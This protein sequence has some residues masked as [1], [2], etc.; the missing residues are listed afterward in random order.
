LLIFVSFFIVLNLT[1]FSDAF[2]FLLA[3]EISLRDL[4]TRLTKQVYDPLPMTRFRPNI[5]VDFHIEEGEE[6][7]PP[8]PPAYDE[9]DWK[10]VRIGGTNNGITFYPVKKCM[11]C[12]LTTVDPEKGE[13]GSTKK[14]GDKDEQPLAILKQYRTDDGGK[15]VFFAQNLIHSYHPSLQKQ[16]VLVGDPIHVIERRGIDVDMTRATTAAAAAASTTTSTPTVSK[17]EEK[18]KEQEETTLLPSSSS[19]TITSDVSSTTTESEDSSHT[20]SE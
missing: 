10:Q 5:I 3:N 4:N 17:K 11:R 7:K 9:D 18:E 2:P 19:S 6:N 15:T 8:L 16:S 20:K 12:K 14:E 13:F 1:S